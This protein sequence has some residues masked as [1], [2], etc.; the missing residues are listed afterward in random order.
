MKKVLFLTPLALAAMT[1]CA[2]KPDQ[3]QAGQWELATETVS[4][5]VPGATPDQMKQARRQVN[6]AEPIQQCFTA[7]QAASLVDDIGR[8]PPNCRTSNKTYAGGVMRIQVS[9][10]A[11]APNMAAI[12]VTLD[13]SF[14]NTTFNATITEQG[15]N[16]TGARE[17][18]RRSARL[19]GRR[20][21]DCPPAPPMPT[22]PT[23][24]PAEPA[25]AGNAAAGAPP[26]GL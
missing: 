22:M 12:E 2:P 6:Q 25:P 11:P 3:I 16:P 7:A 8:G 5:D 21:G 23:M 13:G 20:I 4:F 18:M 24:P 14:T 9:C 26:A 19:R 17:P 15:P 1:G 10:P